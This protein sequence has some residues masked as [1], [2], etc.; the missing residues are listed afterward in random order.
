MTGTAP[1]C[2]AFPNKFR[3]TIMTT[4]MS[5]RSILARASAGAAVAALPVAAG[6][7]R[8]C[9]DPIFAAINLNRK[10]MIECVEARKRLRQH[11]GKIELSGLLIGDYPD[12]RDTKPVR[13]LVA[14]DKWDLEAF[15]CGLPEPEREAWVET[16]LD[17]LRALTKQQMAEHAKTPRGMAW[18]AW[19]ET[20]N[21]LASTMERLIET[22]PTTIA[23]VAAVLQHWLELTKADTG[24]EGER[25]GGT[26]CHFRG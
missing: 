8:A 21:V 25:H 9:E 6:A 12:D 3:R 15:A 22:R 24:M 5:R 19:N 16:K 7:A 20:C 4:R 18:D 23:G 26:T 10:A 2:P 11:R 14:Y 17:D 1:P 13:P